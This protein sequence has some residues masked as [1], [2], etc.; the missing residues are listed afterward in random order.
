[1][2]I[3]RLKLLFFTVLCLLIVLLPSPT[4]AAIDV[5]AGIYRNKPLIF[6][7]SDGVVK[8]IYA[9]FLNAV[10]GEDD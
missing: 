9:D 5:T 2:Q 4:P 1:M 7:D 3:I 10:A 6:R 8:G